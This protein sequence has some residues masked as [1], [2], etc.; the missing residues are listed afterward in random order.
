[1]RPPA[2]KAGALTGLRY[3]P[4]LFEGFSFQKRCKDREYFLINNSQTDVFYVLFSN[5]LN[6]TRLHLNFFFLTE[7]KFLSAKYRPTN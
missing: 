6:F 3:T 2:P 4:L 5:N 7:I 1:P